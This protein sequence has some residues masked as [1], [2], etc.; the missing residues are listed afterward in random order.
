MSIK[1][2][3]KVTG[4]SYSTISR[5][6]NGKSRTD[7]HLILPIQIMTHRTRSNQD[8]CISPNHIP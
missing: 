6:L 5:V 7:T 2:V 4:F 1:E 3:Q 8:L